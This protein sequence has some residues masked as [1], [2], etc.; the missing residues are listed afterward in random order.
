MRRCTDTEQFFKCRTSDKCISK[1]LTC[2]DVA[3]CSDGSDESESVCGDPFARASPRR[4]CDADREFECEANICI[5]Q[6]L[7]CDS[8]NHCSDGRDEAPELCASKNVS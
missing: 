3:D 8:V 2:D 4:K 1:S 7:V 6:K 5:S